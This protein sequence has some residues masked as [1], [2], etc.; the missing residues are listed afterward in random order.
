MGVAVGGVKC[1]RSWILNSYLRVSEKLSGL[2]FG[3]H[4]TYMTEFIALIPYRNLIV[5]SS[6]T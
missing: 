2:M 6:V 3:L 1:K 5:V 4:H